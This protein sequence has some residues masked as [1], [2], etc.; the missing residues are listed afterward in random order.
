MTDTAK[1]VLR[2]LAASVPHVQQYH[3]RS[4]HPDDPAGAD[5]VMIAIPVIDLLAARRV[6]EAKPFFAALEAE[7]EREDEHDDETSVALNEGLLEDLAMQARDRKLTRK[8]MDRYFGPV[9]F[10]AWS[11]LADYVGFFDEPENR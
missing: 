9:T 8:E 7:F 3:E 10:E 6:E 11:E 2:K 1:E 4:V 5:A